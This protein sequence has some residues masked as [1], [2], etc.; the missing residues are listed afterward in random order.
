MQRT[1]V[2]L[3]KELKVRLPD[4]IVETLS[5]K[6]GD[7][8]VV[9]VRGNAII[10]RKVPGVRLPEWVDEDRALEEKEEAVYECIRDID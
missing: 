1:V 5:L 8:L 6:P 10:I 7:K 3:D 2:V 4:T 9:E